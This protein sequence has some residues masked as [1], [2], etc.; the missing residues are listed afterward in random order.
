MI[1]IPKPI[2][3][4][5]K[6]MKS[7]ANEWWRHHL[8]INFGD[9]NDTLRA[10]SFEYRI[11]PIP[12][13]L[14]H[15]LITVQDNGGK[16][17]EST[18]DKYKAIILP[19]LKEMNCEDSFFIKLISRSPKDSLADPNNNFKI[20]PLT[21]IDEAMHAILASMRCF[22]DMVLLRYL[23]FASIVVRPYIEF[24]S[25]QEWRI[26]IKDKKII[27]ISQYDYNQEF[28]ELTEETVRRYDAEIR[29]LINDIVIPNIPLADYIADVI[30]GDNGRPTI[31]L[32]TNP[33]GLSD[34]CLFKNYNSFD[35]TIAWIKEDKIY[36][37]F[38]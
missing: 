33:Y 22:E 35:G 2:L 31:V 18:I 3:P 1:K 32:E 4:T 20:K 21:S 17:I 30:V 37:L 6:E 19:K 26:Y 15:E 8:G 12:C 9:W 7:V 25:F 5:N 13:E 34:P 14:I 29:N 27:G 10:N 24:E 36:N 11:C 23:D 16:G 38:Y 28:K